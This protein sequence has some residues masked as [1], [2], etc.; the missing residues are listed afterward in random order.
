MGDLQCLE[1]GLHLRRHRPHLFQHAVCQPVIRK[2][3]GVKPVIRV[4]RDTGRWE[5]TSYQLRCH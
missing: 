2:A 3:F 4:E 5:E 1:F